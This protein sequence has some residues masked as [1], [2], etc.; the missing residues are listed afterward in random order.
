MRAEDAI[1]EFSTTNSGRCAIQ[2]MNGRHNCG[3]KDLQGKLNKILTRPQENNVFFRSMA[4]YQNK[5]VAVEIDFWRPS[6][7]HTKERKYPEPRDRRKMGLK[8]LLRIIKK[9]SN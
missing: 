1:K 4:L 6:A 9:Q 5:I 3:I 8:I 2:M 7:R